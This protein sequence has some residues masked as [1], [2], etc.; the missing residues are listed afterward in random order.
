[1]RDVQCLA[2][3]A[4]DLVD[5]GV[6][7]AQEDRGVRLLE[8][9]A[10]AVQTG[11]AELLLEQGIDEGGRRPRCGRSRRRVSSRGVSVPR[12]CRSTHASGRPPRCTMRAPNPESVQESTRD[13]RRSV[14]RPPF[15]PVRRH[16]RRDAPAPSSMP[17][18][19]AILDVGA[20]GLGA[21][22]GG[23]LPPGSR[24]TRPDP[25]GVDR[26]GRRR[27]PGRRRQDPS[28]PFTEAATGRATA[29]DRFGLTASG[30]EFVGA[31]LPLLIASGGV[32]VSLG[33][34]GL[35]WAAP[36]ELDDTEREVTHR[37]RVARRAGRRPGAT[38]LD[39]RRSAPS[40]SS[41]WPTP[42]R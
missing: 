28:H 39:R 11:R 32:E 16:R 35:G 10:R 6:L 15:Q 31:Y 26:H 22:V 29:F 40:G 24:P 14:P 8:E 27:P 9:A 25:R 23:H 2:D 30:E 18:L 5:L 13:Q 7:D 20:A 1:M 17:T 42:I 33:S 34:I 37:P 41:G 36:R 3:D 19:Q 12:R 38:R 21:A 4:H